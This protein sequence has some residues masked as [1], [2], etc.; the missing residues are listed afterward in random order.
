MSKHLVIRADAS[1]YIGTGHIMRCIALAQAWQDLGG[2]VT[3]LGHCESERLRRRIIEEGIDFVPAKKPYPNSADLDFTLNYLSNMNDCPSRQPW[4]VLDGYNFSTEYQKAI[5]DVNYRLLV[6]DD[7]NH[8]SHYYC[9]IL[10]NQNIYAEKLSYSCS[11]ECVKL[12]GCKYALLRREFMGAKTPKR[13]ISKITNRILVTLGGGDHENVSLKVLQSLNQLNNNDLE[14][15]IV[16]GPSNPN[17]QSLRKE[18]SRSVFQC[19]LITS[20][21]AMPKLMAWADVAVC[22]G[23]STCYELSYMGLPYMIIILA[24]NQEAIAEGFRK[25]GAAINCGWHYGL[26]T[27]ELSECVAGMISNYDIRKDYSK[28]AMQLVN[29][30][31]ARIVVEHMENY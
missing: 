16:V 17:I 4:I 23:G 8:L 3:F 24:K 30:F 26:S 29:G 21:K 13:E 25:A 7:C 1:A 6:I 31:G 14:V 11:E 5:K 2:A 28:K 18:R 10:V 27:E 19:E 20:P 9:N 12:L 15:K 22:G